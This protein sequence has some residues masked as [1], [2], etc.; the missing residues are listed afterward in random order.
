MHVGL[1]HFLLLGAGLF[2][3]GL[4][5]MLTR[6][7]AIGV[8]MGIELILTASMINF[9]AFSHFSNINLGGEM[10]TFFVLAIA[11]AEAIVAVAIILNVYR[12]SKTIDLR[13]LD[14]LRD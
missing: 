1:T 9:V 3:I 14:Q 7:N 6:R 4:I 8:L 5:T 2:A 10:N 12:T 13:N 11:A